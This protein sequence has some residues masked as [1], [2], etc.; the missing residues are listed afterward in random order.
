[1]SLKEQMA[2]DLADGRVFFNSEEFADWHQING[3]KVLCMLD[4]PHFAPQPIGKQKRGAQASSSRLFIRVEEFLRSPQPGEP[5]EINGKDYLV[6]S[7][8]DDCG[9]YVIQYRSVSDAQ[10][11][12]QIQ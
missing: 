7:I 2:E 10:F 4:S 8:D 3:V 11:V 9:V 12:R 1:M 5:I 6:E